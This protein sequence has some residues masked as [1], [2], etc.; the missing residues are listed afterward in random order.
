[1]GISND[2]QNIDEIYYVAVP[3]NRRTGNCWSEASAQKVAT[4]LGWETVKFPAEITT[5]DF[6][7]A[8][9]DATVITMIRPVD[10][11]DPYNIGMFIGEMFGSNGYGDT[12][13]IFYEIS[14]G[15][16]VAGYDYFANNASFLLLRTASQGCFAIKDSSNRVL[17]FDRFFNP[18]TG[19]EKWG[20][21]FQNVFLDIYT[22]L[23]VGL[24]YVNYTNLGGY[25]ALKKFTVIAQQGVYNA[26]SLYQSYID[27]S[28]TS[29]NIELDGQRYCG[30]VQDSSYNPFYIPLAE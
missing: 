10:N 30:I 26:L 13:P 21:F 5:V 3:A 19:D 22:G 15:T 28:K 20:F 18:K 9:Q 14:T 1:M 12:G 11:D 4:A 16:K 29:K 8:T 2:W 23:T 25:V 7:G 6:N 24:S 27:Y 17:L